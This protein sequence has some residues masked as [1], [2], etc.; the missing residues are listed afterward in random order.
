MNTFIIGLIYASTVW[1][2]MF[3]VVKVHALCLANKFC[4]NRLFSEKEVQSI[5][6]IPKHFITDIM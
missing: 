1:H 2:D 5:F 6:T 4:D 3:P